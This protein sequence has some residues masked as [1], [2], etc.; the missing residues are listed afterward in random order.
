MGLFSVRA[1]VCT[2]LPTDSKW[3]ASGPGHPRC[4]S[5]C[6]PFTTLAKSANPPGIVLFN[7]N[8]PSVA[9]FRHRPAVLT[10]CPHCA[11]VRAVPD[12][13]PFVPPLCSLSPL[14]P[15]SVHSAL[16]ECLGA[17]CLSHTFVSMRRSPDHWTLGWFVLNP[18]SSSHEPVCDSLT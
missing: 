12:T 13:Q 5:I 18:N 3:P 11:P 10:L 4:G 17:S 2:H 16:L 9:D 7:K 1:P 6:T 15:L 14:S 8:R